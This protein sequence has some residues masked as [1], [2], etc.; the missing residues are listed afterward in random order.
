MA[1]KTT[2]SRTTKKTTAAKKAAGKAA[3]PRKQAQ[4]KQT[5]G[6]LTAPRDFQSIVMALQQFWVEQGCVLWQPYSQQVGAG[7]MNPATFLRVIGP[8]PWNVAYVEPSVRP[9]DGRY[10][11]NPNRLQQHHQFQV[12]LKPDPG[13]PQEMYLRSLQAIGIDVHKHDIRFVEDNWASPALGA[14]GLG[15]E[16]WLDGLEITQ[17]TYF[18]QAGGIT[19]EPVSVEITYGLDRIA[20]ALQDVNYVGDVRWSKERNW[21]DLNMQ[22]EREQ[23]KYYFEIADVERLRQLYDLYEAEG[24]AALDSGLL[25]PA[26]DYMLRTSHAFNVLD[27]RG[28]IG[29]T[30]RQAYFRRMRALASRV[31]EAYAAER[32]RE[33]YPWL[34]EAVDAK[35][36]A[37]PTK[38]TGPKTASDFLLEI[39]TEELPPD[40]LTSAI[41]QL[42][43]SLEQL[44]AAEHL[45]HKGIRVQ[46]TP[47][48]LAAIVSGLAPKQPD[49]NQVVKGPPA[50]RAFGADGTP[51]PAA[52]GFARGQ[53]LPVT[54]LKVETI[55]GGEYAVARVERKG[56]LAAEVLAETLPE[57][58]AGLK[59]EKSMRWNASGIA[60]S[61]P[62][63]WLLALHGEALVPFAY[64]GLH[65][66]K[67]S[68][69][70]RLSKGEQFAVTNAKD[71]LAKLKKQGILL[72]VDQRKT[73][74]QNQIAKLA[75][76]A[77][78]STPQDPGLL[79]EVTHLIEAP[80][81]LLGEFDA[82]YLE[83]PQEVLTGVMKKHQRYFP[84]EKDGTLLNYFIAVAN[85]EIDAKAVT[86]GNAA[87]LRAR[88]ADAAYFIRKDREHPL[89]HYVDGLKQL[90]FQK[91]LGSM[92]D[93][94]QR[95]AELTRVFSPSLG[96]DSAES[97]IAHR[98]A[99]LSKADLVTKMVV[100]MT[101]LQGVIGRTYA[102]ESGEPP[103]VAEAIFEH[104][105]PRYA[106][107]RTPAGKAGLA[108]GIAD[109]LDSL[110]GLFAVGLAPT[111]AKDP[112]AQ[113]RA[114]IGLVQ[115]LIAGELHFD[116]R[117]AI[118]QAAA[119]QPVT[120]SEK[121]QQDT[122]DFIVGRLRALLLENGERHDVV[123]A[124][125]AEQ[126]HNPAAAARAIRQLAAHSAKADWPQTLAAFARCVRITRDLKETYAVDEAGLADEAERGLLAA[127]QRAEAA[128]HAAGSVDE[129]LAAF[130]P[131]IPAINTFFDKVMVMADDETVRRNRLGLLQR[132]AALAN[133]VAD[134]S[135]LE[136]F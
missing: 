70:L 68:R 42:S 108:V 41:Q 77:G 52:E 124:V 67:A 92:W 65:S 22:A 34:S 97:E 100:E 95:V 86:A 71:Y 79:E 8:E 44:L 111:G 31:A 25:L 106:G 14:W 48:R 103:A 128:P 11:E 13:N 127:L 91:E 5:A 69:G 36:A 62:V 87:V 107:D 131:M 83:L 122:L 88:F 20:M 101:S 109:R 2:T 55:D 16:V 66:A 9:D 32:Q 81:A 99:Q 121:V 113:R 26:Y 59:F 38:I 4:P 60:F 50:A 18:Q 85:G 102:L 125:L 115:N 47:R 40:D 72:D 96:L 136:G 120:A 129:M 21:G 3:A 57:L 63:R 133:G 53:G 114:A 35:P 39:G 134:F 30:E 130:M 123:D 78:G 61:R 118:H 90:T 75:A 23:S 82:A 19:L 126:G 73:T 54:A 45:A 119:Q 46:G 104:Y 112:F 1:K 116:L 27:A 56:R 132:V 49:L 135:K 51:T 37:K 6:K 80:T 33:E 10:G 93:K 89:S 12:I 110:T 7:T 15:W 76:K 28:A 94:A 117:Q 105:L 64:A 74:I 24:I 29:V 84:V 58:I 43:A 17:F 98:A